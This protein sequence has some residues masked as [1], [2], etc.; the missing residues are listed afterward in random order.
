M[1]TEGIV[2][3]RGLHLRFLQE[4]PAF[5][6]GNVHP[7]I[8]KGYCVYACNILWPST[9]IAASSPQK[10]IIMKNTCFRTVLI[11][12]LLASGLIA[13]VPSHAQEKAGLNTQKRNPGSYHSITLNIPATVLL[14]QSGT[15]SFEIEGKQ[16]LIDQIV[17]EVKSDRLVIKTKDNNRKWASD[18]GIRIYIS[19]PEL[20]D[21]LVNGSG[22]I[23]A[24]TDFST[25]KMT[26]TINGSGRIQTKKITAGSLS[27]IINGSGD[28]LGLQ[29]TVEN[30]SMEINGSGNI[31]ADG[32]QSNQSA[33]SIS[34]SG[35]VS[36]G[37]IGSM[38]VNIAG[39]GNVSYQGNPEKVEKKIA[40]SGKVSP[41]Q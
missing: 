2:I 17:T 4:I 39:S 40:G 20:R 7:K 25:D 26:L 8:N 15:S 3:R 21:L 18:Q 38:E 11:L 9:A 35:N 5:Q 37:S 34:G 10:G 12:M 14:S 22:E 24:Q 19:N 16:E 23:A 32:L 6:V 36:A 41:Q 30:L 1:N 29:G 28:I 27:A 33:V 13:S 31:K